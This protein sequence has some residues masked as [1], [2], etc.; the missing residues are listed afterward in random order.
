MGV[1]LTPEEDRLTAE[2]FAAWKFAL[3]S[4]T[5]EEHIP[6]TSPT[7]LTQHI[8]SLMDELWDYGF[9]RTEIREAFHD[10]VQDMPRYA[11]DERNGTGIRGTKL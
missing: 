4:R 2:N 3:A 7:S 11:A 10:A 6:S 9:S 8:N 5:V 1:D